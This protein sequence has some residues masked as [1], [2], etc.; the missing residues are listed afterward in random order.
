MMLMVVDDDDDDGNDGGGHGDGDVDEIVPIS[1]TP[2]PCHKQLKGCS[3]CRARS[4]RQGSFCCSWG[5][6]ANS[7]QRQHNNRKIV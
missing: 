5:T 2:P 6:S 7:G 4:I 3:R 1:C